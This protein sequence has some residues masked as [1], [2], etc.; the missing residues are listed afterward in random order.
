[1]ELQIEKRK[2]RQRKTGLLKWLSGLFISSKTEASIGLSLG[3]ESMELLETIKNARQDWIT[4]NINFEQADNSKMVDYYT[5][6]IKACEV[7]YE[8]LI[9]KA[10]DQGIK[11]ELLEASTMI[12]YDNSENR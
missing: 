5:Y 6:K 2:H 8:Y 3:D 12:S 4:A 1:M 11:S 7:R 10:K 9:K